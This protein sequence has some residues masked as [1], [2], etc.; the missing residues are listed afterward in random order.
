MF[1]ILFLS[2]ESV[3]SK[4]WREI[5]LSSSMQKKVCLLACDEAHCISE[6]GED[7]RPAYKDVLHL[8]S[9]FVDVPVLGVTA[10]CD[11]KVRKDIF[12]SLAFDDESLTVAVVPDRPNI[13]LDIRESKQDHEKELQWLLDYLLRDTICL[14][15]IIVYCRSVTST[16]TLYNHVKDHLLLQKKSVQIIDMFHRNIDEDSSVRILQSF[17]D[18]DS[19]LKCLFSTVAFG[20]GVQIP[21][22]ELVVHWG[23]PKS[24]LCYWQE[25]GR[26]GRD[27]RDA[28]AICYA[29]GRSLIKKITDEKMISVAKSSLQKNACIRYSVLKNME[30]KGMALSHLQEN[31]QSCSGNEDQ[32]LASRCCTFCS[33]KCSCGNQSKVGDEFGIP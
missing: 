5:F 33:L 23:V 6:W 11:E 16:A 1:S 27:E 19:E 21:D 32:C 17:K 12:T 14:K 3:R 24:V 15:K 10:T 30:I 22:V 31:G 18:N 20:M 8:R 4:F 13:Y 28:Y 29:Y 25:V 9:M 26:G 2:P 7:F